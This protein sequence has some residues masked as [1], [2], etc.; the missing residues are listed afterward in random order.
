MVTGTQRC[1]RV[2]DLNATYGSEVGIGKNSVDCEAGLV[3]LDKLPSGLLALRFAR[4]I[5]SPDSIASAIKGRAV[6]T[7]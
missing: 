2:V 3:L 5:H 1:Q 7:A 4:T 6:S